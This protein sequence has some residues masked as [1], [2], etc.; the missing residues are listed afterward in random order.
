MITGP[1]NSIIATIDP[2]PLLPWQYVVRL[3]PFSS[4]DE[5][6]E[7]IIDS[8]L[9][10][11][12]I[13]FEDLQPGELYEATAA[14]IINDVEGPSVELGSVSLRKLHLLVLLYC[15]HNNVYV[16]SRYLSTVG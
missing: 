3:H 1:N 11:P 5:T 15:L 14:S 7:I 8:S 6:K 9:P 4:P 10:L 2:A 13:V 16:L 12:D